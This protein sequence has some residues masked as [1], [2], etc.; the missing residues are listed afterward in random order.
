MTDDRD[1]A[2]WR[3]RKRLAHYA[4]DEH[5]A[6]LVAKAT[7]PSPRAAPTSGDLANLR[8]LVDEV[9]GPEHLSKPS[10]L[11]AVWRLAPA[12]PSH[13]ACYL[14]HAVKLR[15]TVTLA[16][17][18][19]AIKKVRDQHER[20]V[21]SNETPDDPAATAQAWAARFTRGPAWPS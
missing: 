13:F 18:Q 14:G 21:A 10:D 7:P 5:L 16:G 8:A 11:K 20:I 4:D 1:D 3:G 2:V 6:N 19:A 9:F 12:D 17:K 15:T